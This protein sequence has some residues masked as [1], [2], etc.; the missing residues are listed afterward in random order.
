MNFRNLIWIPLAALIFAGAA[1]AAVVESTETDDVLDAVDE[2][3]GTLTVGPETDI[4][5]FVNGTYVATAVLQREQGAPG[6][7]S[8]AA[9]MDVTNG[10]DNATVTTS[11]KSGP[12]TERFRVAMTAFTSGDLLAQL[13]DGATTAQTF[14]E[15]STYIRYFEDWF[16]AEQLDTESATDQGIWVTDEDAATGTIAVVTDTID[17]GGV[18][19][20]SGTTGTNNDTVCLSFTDV[21][22][23]NGLISDGWTA[24]EARLRYDVAAGIQLGVSLL[25]VEC[26][27]TGIEPFDVDTNVVTFA[28]A[29]YENGAGWQ[30]QDDADDTDGWE[31]VSANADTVG[32]NADE[33]EAATSVGI[34]TYERVRLE[35]DSAGDGYW[36]FNGTLVY[37]ENEVVA[38]TARLA[39]FIWINTS[40]VANTAV[41]T[42]IDYVEFVASRPST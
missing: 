3:T 6:S 4:T 30:L 8:W 16:T 41:T 11:H 12:N 25:D 23:Q 7:G 37:A 19:I 35:I 10:T 32:N 27:A 42:I 31:P 40:D 38:T 18:T 13:T 39:P 2:V 22:D 14:A 28:T 26:A 24:V 5:I 36:Y 33:F 15:G 34:N 20:V 29:T 1:Q 21:T 17:E 9:V